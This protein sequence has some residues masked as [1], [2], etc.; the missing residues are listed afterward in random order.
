MSE[1]GAVLGHPNT[2]TS[3]ILTCQMIRL[4]DIHGLEGIVAN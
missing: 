1:A 3:C 4:C 2:P